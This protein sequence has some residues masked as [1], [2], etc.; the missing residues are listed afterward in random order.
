MLPS[1][2]EV[3]KIHETFRGL[4]GDSDSMVRVASD[5]WAATAALDS[6][7]SVSKFPVARPSHCSYSVLMEETASELER[8]KNVNDG[9]RLI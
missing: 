3:S 1:L 4:F 9:K 5:V 8:L 6:K 7:R 2:P